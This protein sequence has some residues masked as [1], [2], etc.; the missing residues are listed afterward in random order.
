MNSKIYVGNILY[1]I[2][3]QDLRYLFSAYGEV[4]SAEAIRN[5][6]DQKDLV[7][8]VWVL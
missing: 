7:L 6:K 5:Q 4:A 8:Y 1:E 2:T 3:D